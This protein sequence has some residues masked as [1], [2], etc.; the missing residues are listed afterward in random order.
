MKDKKTKSKR[1]GRKYPRKRTS[2]KTI[3]KGKN[4]KYQ[5]RKKSIR[6]QY[7]GEDKKEKNNDIK[8]VKPLRDDPIVIRYMMLSH[9][10]IEFLPTSRIFKEN[11][12]GHYLSMIKLEDLLNIVNKFTDYKK[13]PKIQQIFNYKSSYLV[14]KN[15]ITFKYNDIKCENLL[16]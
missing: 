8:I 6:K 12:L 10:V 2:K 15:K 14:N 1:R 3:A 11:N 16:L 7:G 9:D 4:K 5:I 13:S